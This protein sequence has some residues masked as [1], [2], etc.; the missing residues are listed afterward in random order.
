MPLLWMV[1]FATREKVGNAFLVCYF[2]T[3]IRFGLKFTPEMLLPLLV[4]QQL[5]WQ[6]VEK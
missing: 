5:F 1:L 3:R 6:H 2:R 4:T